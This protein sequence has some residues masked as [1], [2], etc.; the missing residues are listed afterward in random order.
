M[1]L[2]GEIKS[3]ATTQVIDLQNDFLGVEKRRWVLA[4]DDDIPIVESKQA[5]IGFRYQPGNSY[6]YIFRRTRHRQTIDARHAQGHGAT[7]RR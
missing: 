7:G 3:Q 2:L 1:E 6:R 4:N 5:S